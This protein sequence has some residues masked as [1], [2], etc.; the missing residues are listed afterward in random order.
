MGHAED[1]LVTLARGLAE[2]AHGGQVDKA[3]QPYISHP[4]R[5][6]A[7]LETDYEIAVAWLHDV[8]EDTDLTVQDLRDYGLPQ[9]VVSAVEALTRRLGEDPQ[10]YY[11]RVAGDRLATR[12]KFADLEDNSD[13]VR[14]ALLDEST[15]TRL[16]AKYRKGH[17]LLTE[18]GEASIG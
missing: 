4:A 13:P 15:R 5:V 17:A 1:P 2:K 7:R 16:I 14:L 18:L 12:V 6:A 8:L 11:Q 9:Q 10:E 3:G